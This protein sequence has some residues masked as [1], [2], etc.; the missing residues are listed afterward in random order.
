MNRVCVLVRSKGV[1][2]LLLVTLQLFLTIQTSDT[3]S[4]NVGDSNSDD[5]Q[6]PQ[7]LQPE[8]FMAADREVAN[9]TSIERDF[10]AGP[11]PNLTE[12]DRHWVL[13]THET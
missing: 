6:Q 13:L 4:Q 1:M 10:E 2:L 8:D 9:M 3:L 7:Q 12:R 11:P 5:A